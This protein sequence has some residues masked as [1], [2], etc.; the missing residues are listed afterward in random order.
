MTCAECVTFRVYVWDWNHTNEVGHEVASRVYG[1]GMMLFCQM[2]CFC[3][4]IH[5][6]ERLDFL[7]LAVVHLLPFLTG[8]LFAI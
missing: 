3:L 1:A 6:S 2:S 4:I 5:I 7:R 8:A